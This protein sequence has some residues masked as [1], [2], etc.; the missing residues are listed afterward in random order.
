LEVQGLDA[1]ARK[2]VELDVLEFKKKIMDEEFEEY[3]R[4]VDKKG[5]VAEKDKLKQ[6]ARLDDLASDLNNYVEKINQS[7]TEAMEV[8][9]DMGRTILDFASSL[10][11][12]LGESLTDTESTF[13]D[14][15]GNILLLTLD[16]LRQIVTMAIA[17]RTIKNI[18]T[19]G[20]LG[21][22]KAAG[23]IALINAAFYAVKGLIKKPTVSGSSSDTSA[24]GE[25]K[26][27]TRTVTGLAS[28]GYMPVT[29]AQDGANYMAA[30]DPGRRGFVS[31]PTVL[32]GESGPEFVVSNAGINN[33]TVRPL[34]DLI[35]SS[36]RAGTIRTV[37]LN[38]IMRT[39]MA[40]F[41]SGGFTTVTE[42]STPDM[43]SVSTTANTTPVDNRI[44]NELI[45]LLRSLNTNGVRAWLVYSQFEKAKAVI[46]KA[47]KIGSK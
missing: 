15:M 38:Q 26:S 37:D 2:K 40:G 46:E 20:P 27:G 25:S 23:E 1:E 4:M 3:I 16:T 45:Y 28:G 22:A 14:V 19:L 21:I 6:S 17:E 36:Q 9:K 11:Q 44:L 31:Q 10:G 8:R 29:R 18:A 32:V 34:I 35:D 30:Y 42:T 33:P 43:P 7:G 39:R 24:S 12:T 41:A 13:A 5:K 47:Q